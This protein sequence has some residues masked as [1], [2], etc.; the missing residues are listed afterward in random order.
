M[1][2]AIYLVEDGLVGYQ[3][4]GT[5]KARCPS[6]RDFQG[7]GVGVGEWGLSG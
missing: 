7:I 4:E 1:P 6:V 5:V 2:P 3:W